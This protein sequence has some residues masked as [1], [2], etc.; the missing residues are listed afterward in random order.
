MEISPDGKWIAYDT[1]AGD[2]PGPRDIYLLAIDGSS[3]RKL[4][5]GE[6]RARISVSC[7][8]A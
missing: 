8:V 7:V 3:E 2:K 1:F 6:R 5:S 4:A